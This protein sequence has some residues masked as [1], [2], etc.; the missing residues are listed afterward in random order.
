MKAVSHYLEDWQIIPAAGITVWSVAVSS[1]STNPAALGFATAPLL[2]GTV[3]WALSGPTRWLLLLFPILLLTPPFASSVAGGIGLHLGPFAAALGLLAGVLRPSQWRPLHGSVA[4]ALVLFTGVL[5]E[6]TVVAAWYS[7]LLI[8]AGTLLRVL[9]FGL[10]AYVFVYTWM[11]PGSSDAGVLRKARFLFW[12]G[13]ASAAFA[14]LD[15]YYQFPAPTG[16]SEQYVWLEE[17]VFRRAQGVFYDASMLGNVCVFFLV[18]ILISMFQPRDQAIC[19]RP[20]LVIAAMVFSVALILSYSRASILSF[21]VAIAAYAR[22]RRFRAWKSLGAAT[23]LLILAALVLHFVMPSISCTYWSRLAASFRYIGSSPDG[24][25]SGRLTS[26]TALIGF[27]ERRPWQVLLGI[28]YKTLPYTALAGQPTIA[29]NT[30]LSLLVETGIVGLAAF[31]WLNGA[32]LQTAWRAAHSPRGQAAFFGS[33]I[34]CFWA[35]QLFQMLSGDLIT[36]WRVLPLYFWGLAAAA[37]EATDA[38]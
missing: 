31:L 32:I 24:V 17:G 10:G 30:Y 22:I 23:A 13:L 12:M 18:M 25:L 5:V 9:L 8:A 4:V 38:A 2:I 6:S 14:C 1:F 28:G 33:W 26:W 35:G 36:Y 19:S 3:C 21:G 27:V 29:D 37:R 20:V 15:F 7:G 34:F 11:G 16:H